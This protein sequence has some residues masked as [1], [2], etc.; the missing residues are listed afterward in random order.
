MIVTPTLHMVLPNLKQDFVHV[1][2]DKHSECPNLS[3][4][5]LVDGKS[6]LLSLFALLSKTNRFPYLASVI[7]II[8]ILLDTTATE[9]ATAKIVCNPNSFWC[10]CYL[11]TT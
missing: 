6:F 4:H 2:T 8:V 5:P 10:L 9:N 7:H 1:T 3:C 11:H